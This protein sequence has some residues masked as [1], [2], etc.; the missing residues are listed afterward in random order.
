MAKELELPAA[1]KQA[2]WKVKIQDKERMEP[3][4]VSLLKGTDKWRVNLRTGGFMD[5]KPD[6]SEVPDELLGILRDE[7][8]WM[9]A[10]EA[11]DEMYPDNPVEGNED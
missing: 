10:I 5:R 3:P 2:G 1:L 7:Q 8:N 9:W 11:W 6:P 4:H